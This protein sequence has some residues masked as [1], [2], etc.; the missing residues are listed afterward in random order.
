MTNSSTGFNPLETL[1]LLYADARDRNTEVFGDYVDTRFES[2][3][4]MVRRATVKSYNDTNLGREVYGIVLSIA[5]AAFAPNQRSSKPDLQALFGMTRPENPGKCRVMMLQTGGGDPETAFL[6]VPQTYGDTPEDKAIIADYPAFYYSPGKF[7]LIPGSFVW[8]KYDESTF[9][10]GVITDHDTTVSPYILSGQAYTPLTSN[11]SFGSAADMS[12]FLEGGAPR[13][14][15]D[16]PEVIQRAKSLGL[17]TWTT[18]W[19]L[20]LYG[21]RS[22]NRTADSYDDVLGVVYVN[23]QEEWVHHVWPGTTD[24]GHKSLMLKAESLQAAKEKGGT[25]IL[26]PGQYVDTW[27]LDKHGKYKY[28]ALTQRGGRTRVYRDPSEDIKLDLDPATIDKGWFGINIHA[29]VSKGTPINASRVGLQSAGCQVHARA[30]GFRNMMALS[31]N[32]IQRTGHR[33]FSYTLLDAW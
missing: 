30:D 7:P 25:A 23:D 3:W 4:D 29:S 10:S 8:G 20:W 2:G 15:G 28:L 32:Q 26:V 1:A 18:P 27:T 33:R 16:P 22:P 6:P 9:Q 21:I 14:L 24:P 31:H 12:G 19:R 5:P 11:M 13:E 17:Q